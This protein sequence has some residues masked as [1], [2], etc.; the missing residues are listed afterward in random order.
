M[1]NN[2]NIK[3]EENNEN[4]EDSEEVKENVSK[5]KNFDS[6]EKATFETPKNAEEKNIEYSS[7]IENNQLKETNIK[8]D[9]KNEVSKTNLQEFSGENNKM[10]IPER[11]KNLKIIQEEKNNEKS[12]KKYYFF[13]IFIIGFVILIL[14]IIIG[15]III[16]NLKKDKY[17]ILDDEES[18][19]FIEGDIDNA[20]NKNYKAIISIDFGSSYS[21]FAI[22]YGENS[23]ESK[24]ENIQPTTIVILKNSLQGYRY[25]NEAE[26]FMN[27]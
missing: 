23:I 9:Y 27:E 15:K 13:T 5:E 24:I 8:D 4:F 2:S 12:G 18:E 25:G 6:K 17:I 16:F 10:I 3:H 26:N 20:T 19:T 11:A 7:K 21:G 14:S 1:E 22:A